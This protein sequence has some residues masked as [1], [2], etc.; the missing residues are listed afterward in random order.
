MVEAPTI[1][2]DEGLSLAL[3]REGF[4]RAEAHGFEV[5]REELCLL[6]ID[7]AHGRRKVVSYDPRTDRL[8]GWPGGK[9]DGSRARA[10]LS[11]FSTWAGDLVRELTPRYASQIQIGRSSYRPRRIENE[12]LSWRKDDR[13][14][15]LDAFRTRPVGGRRI[16]RLFANVDAER[17]RVWDLGEDFTHHALR[18]LPLTQLAPFGVPTLLA[19]VGITKAVRT[20]YDQLMLQL[21]DLAKSD[22]GYQRTSRLR[23]ET[24]APGET[25]LAFTDQI[26]HAVVAGRMLLEQTFY[27]P[28]GALHDERRSPLRILERMT[29]RPLA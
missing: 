13:R 28:V 14:L 21:H 19:A 29:D 11:R 12:P 23:Q 9:A 3:E 8:K 17:Q 16:L 27:L 6:D 26:P 24:F 5:S 4:A 7:A 2:P 22:D 20:P 25:W 15:H 10:M 18:F 1:S